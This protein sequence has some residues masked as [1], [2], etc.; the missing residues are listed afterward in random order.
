MS[1]SRVWCDDEKTNK[2]IR[3]I[4]KPLKYEFWTYK[5]EKCDKTYF[6]NIKSH[7]KTRKPND[8]PKTPF[9]RNCC[10]FDE[11]MYSFILLICGRG[12]GIPFFQII[13]TPFP[14]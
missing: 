11:L 6:I 12:A 2:Q 5:G 4:Y 7:N 9:L 8:W 1:H 13:Q 10:N 3:L 14:N